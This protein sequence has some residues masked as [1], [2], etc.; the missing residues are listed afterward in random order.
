LQL[1]IEN[2]GQDIRETNY[3]Q[4]EHARRGYVYLSWNDGAARLLVPQ[5]LEVELAEMRAAISVIVSRGHMNGRDAL[6]LLF[7]DGSDNP[8]CIHL[9]SEQ[10]DRLLPASEQGRSFD[11][12]VWTANGKQLQLPA[13]YRVAS[14]PYLKPWQD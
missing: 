6:E 5:A 3:W 14:L 9:G 13:R 10:T 4:S 12:T 8:Y 11:F 1:T 7:E 2:D